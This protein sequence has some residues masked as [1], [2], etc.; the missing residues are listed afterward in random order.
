MK[1]YGYLRVST[2]D[3]DNEK[4]KDA[5]LRYANAHNLGHVSFVE[6]KVSGKASW[7]NR[8]LGSLIEDLK[9][10]DVI[11]VPELSRL[12][13]SI[14]QIYEIIS[15][16]QEKQIE[17][18]LIKQHL[19]IGAKQ[20]QTTKIM[21][22]TFALLAEL[23]ADFTSERTREGLAAAKKSGKRLGRPKGSG[24]S[25]LDPYKEEILAARLA[26][27]P[28]SRIAQNHEVSQGTVWNWLKKQQDANHETH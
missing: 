8:K 20:D 24:S 22:S 27:I 17:L 13:R 16:C 11:I 14:K 15:A 5:I 25:K 19:I 10:G 26:G 6:E 18:H 12:A 7:K 1:T 21:I 23:E 4:F 28:V 2:I 3:Q 9:S